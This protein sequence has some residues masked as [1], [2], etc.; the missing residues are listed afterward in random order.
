MIC[1]RYIQKVT[2]EKYLDLEIG[3]GVVQSSD[4]QMTLLSCSYQTQLIPSRFRLHLVL[5]NY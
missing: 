3:C 4:K 5:Q 2:I 1:N